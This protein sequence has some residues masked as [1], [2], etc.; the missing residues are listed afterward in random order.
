MKPANGQ[1]ISR[2]APVED[3]FN[4]LSHKQTQMLA[5]LHRYFGT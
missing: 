3:F 5:Q 4:S 1:E 2:Y